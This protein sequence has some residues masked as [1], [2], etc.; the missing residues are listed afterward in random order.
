MKRLFID[1]N[2]YLDFY[3]AQSR[4]IR[5]LLPPLGTVAE[6]VFITEQIVH[7]VGRNKLA[8]AKRNFDEVLKRLKTDMGVPDFVVDVLGSKVK[9]GFGPSKAQLN[10]VEKAMGAALEGMVQSTDMVSSGL[11]SV[12]RRAVRETEGELR[13]ARLR[14]ER[15]NPPGKKGDTLGDQLSWEQLLG[16]LSRGDELWIVSRDSDYCIRHS[17]N[18]YLHPV[19]FEDLRKRG[20]RKKDIFAFENLASAL[21]DFNRRGGTKAARLPSAKVL[22][23]AAA[24]QQLLARA[25]TVLATSIEKEDLERAIG[26]L[27]PIQR[28]AFV[29]HDL[30]NYSP[31]Q[32]TEMVGLPNAGLVRHHLAMARQGLR[33][34]L[35]VIAGE[36]PGFAIA[37]HR[38]PKKSSRKR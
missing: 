38:G 34:R 35:A 4:A 21:K 31:E 8:I 19:L 12:F 13:L 7:E 37:V 5:K 11:Q 9:T 24:E 16:R 22:Q 17:G 18:C 20:L 14:R 32:I 10:K 23:D 36:R 15:G 30:E 2:I 33:D 29:L 3:D 1:A 27:S 26:K 6:N 28:I 25:E